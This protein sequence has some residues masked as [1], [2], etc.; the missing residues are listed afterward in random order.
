MPVDVH[1]RPTVDEQL[2]I[3]MIRAVEDRDMEALLAAYHPDVE[4]VWPPQLPYG[5]TYC[6]AEIQAM[7]ETFA[8]LWGPLQPDAETRRLDPEILGSTED[9]VTARYVQRGRDQEGRTHEMPVIGL[10]TLLGGRVRRLQMF[11]FDP[12]ATARFLQTAQT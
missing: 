10:Y 2:I 7:S 12:A 3:D 11:Y 8:T 5:G 6:G 1:E 4:F 9:H